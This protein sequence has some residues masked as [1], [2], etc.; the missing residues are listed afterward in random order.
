MGKTIA[1]TVQAQRVVEQKL[2]LVFD[3]DW[4]IQ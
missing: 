4:E 1:R 3:Q 2:F